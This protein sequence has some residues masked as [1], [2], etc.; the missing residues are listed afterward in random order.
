MNEILTN[1][2]ILVVLIQKLVFIKSMYFLIGEKMKDMNALAIG[3]VML[4]AGVAI[5]AG[6][7]EG[8]II[9]ARMQQVEQTY[10]QQIAQL[11]QQ[12]AQGYIQPSDIRMSVPS[13]SP[14]VFNYTAAVNASDDVATQSWA[15]TS[16]HFAVKDIAPSKG[17]TTTVWLKLQVAGQDDGL[18]AALQKNE[19]QVYAYTTG[20]PKTWL[21]GTSDWQGGF[22]AG[23]P[24]TLAAN[25]E[26]DLNLATTMKACNDVFEDG[27]SYTVTL[28]LWE[29]GTGP[30]GNGDVVDT[31][32]FTLNT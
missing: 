13:G 30:H 32:T 16:I 28:Y 18:P 20:T 29:P 26:F 3:V 12:A 14:T 25:Q 5:T 31:L 10:Q 4:I 15:N 11:S 22:K 21:W 23:V 1:L 7:Y 19:F 2:K 17:G 9:P 27:Q 8:N 6:L 24:I